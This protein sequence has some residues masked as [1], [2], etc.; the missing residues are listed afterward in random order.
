MNG[1][2]DRKAAHIIYPF[3]GDQEYQRI[4]MVPM[5]KKKKGHPTRGIDE[6]A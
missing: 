6:A 3:Q 5:W 1:I 4:G 2:D